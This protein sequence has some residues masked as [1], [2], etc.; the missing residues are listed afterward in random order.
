MKW[1]VREYINVDENE[2]QKLTNFIDT[3]KGNNENFLITLIDK[4]NGIK[5]RI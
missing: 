5:Y 3:M 1:I 2:Y 4:V